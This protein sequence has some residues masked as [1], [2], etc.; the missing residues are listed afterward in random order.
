M[1]LLCARSSCTSPSLLFSIH[2]F[3]TSS[4]LNGLALTSAAANRW[5]WVFAMCSKCKNIIERMALIFLCWWLSG[6]PPKASWFDT[7]G[8]ETQTFRNERRVRKGQL[9]LL[10]K[11]HPG[12]GLWSA[13][14]GPSPRSAS[15]FTS[16][17]FHPS[18]RHLPTHRGSQHRG[19][20]CSKPHHSSSSFSFSHAPT[21]NCPSSGTD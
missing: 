18:V 5:L 6:E 13:G 3:Q 11:Y 12:L 7:A 21:Q 4:L 20:V 17:A 16:Q 8:N 15:S 19:T 2:H 1:K 14:W 10:G 9:A